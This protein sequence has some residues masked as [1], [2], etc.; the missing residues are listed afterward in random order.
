MLKRYLSGYPDIGQAAAARL[1]FL[2]QRVDNPDSLLQQAIDEKVKPELLLNALQKGNVQSRQE[3]KKADAGN[4]EDTNRGGDEELEGDFVQVPQT[5]PG[6]PHLQ[7]RIERP[8]AIP[9]VQPKLGPTLGVQRSYP[10]T[11]QARP[12]EPKK[13]GKFLGINLPKFSM[14]SFFKGGGQKV[15]AE[16]EAQPKAGKNKHNIVKIV[17]VVVFVL[18]VAVA[19]IFVRPEPRQSV[20]ANTPTA[21]TEP[22]WF[23]IPEPTL[24]PL[25]FAHNTEP[26]MVQVIIGI[27]TVL[28]SLFV[29]LD[30]LQ[31]REQTDAY[32]SAGAIA[33]ML[34]AGAIFH[35]TKQSFFVGVMQF[36]ENQLKLV[37]ILYGLLFF[38]LPFAVVYVVSAQGRKDW[39][40]EGGFLSITGAFG[41]LFGT[42]GLGALAV[43]FIIPDNPAYPVST[44]WGMLWHKQ[45]AEM[46]TSILI[47]LLLGSGAVILGLEAYKSIEA[48]DMGLELL[49]TTLGSTLLIVLYPIGRIVF[50]DVNPLWIFSSTLGLSAILGLQQQQQK[51]K[52]AQDD[53]S[54]VSVGEV[55]QGNPPIPPYD[56]LAWQV[57]ALLL[58]IAVLGRV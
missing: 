48:A 9:K 42:A 44:L 20:T 8:T 37:E 6:Q 35:A 16:K 10:P 7:P 32:V 58:A 13:K 30:A 49:F 19:L 18:L 17:A 34:I 52:A 57:A 39:T 47:F 25:D 26:T 12:S 14:P 23:S 21:T 33:V 55:R 38:G 28:I 4:A 22:N 46:G 15:E 45:F 2:L 43:L 50:P 29:L 5:H 40:P 51:G 11:P 41:L 54:P 31:R 24:I 53:R 36:N 27:G 3:P 56:K 1:K